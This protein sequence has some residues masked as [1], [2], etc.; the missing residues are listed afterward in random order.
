MLNPTLHTRNLSSSFSSLCLNSGQWQPLSAPKAKSLSLLS[1]A[2]S[3]GGKKAQRRSGGIRCSS[4]AAD[5]AQVSLLTKTKIP[6]KLKAVVTVNLT[7]GGIFSH[8]GIT[9]GLDDFADLMGRSIYLELLSK[10]LDPKTGS[11][12][13]PVGAYAHKIGH[14]PKEAK[15]E[16]EFSIPQEFGGVGAILVTNE[17]HKEIY[18]KDIVL[19]TDD[20]ESSSFTI[21]CQSWVHSKFDNHD[22]RIFFASKSYLPSD[23]PDG[24]KEYR[25][26]ELK[27]LRGNGTGERKVFERI[28]DYDV[29]NDLGDP[30]IHRDNA[31]PVLGGSKQFP[32]PRRC[33]T[34]RP[35][36]KSDPKMEKRAGNFYIPRDEAFSEIKQ[37]QFSA[38]TLRSVMHAVVPSINSALVD[39]NRSFPYFTA[40]DS[41]FDEGLNLGDQGDNAGN[42]FSTVI[43]RL[44]KVVS[45][46]DD[47][48]LRFEIPEMMERDKF[49]WFRD[50]EFSRQTL[51]G[52]NPF[53]IQLLT[54]FP[55]FSKL[56]PKIY[57]PA[58]SDI[59]K[60]II[61][62]EIRG[63]MTVE[64]ALKEKKLFILDFHDLYLPYVHKVR[65]LE[66]TT[67]Y[68]SRTIFFLNPDD[69]L[70]PIAIELTR[71]KSPTKP[72]WRQVFIN[73]WDATGTWLWRLAK[74]HVGAHDTGYHQLV[75]HWL[76]TH[77][78]AEP[79]I[80]ASNRQLS[81]MHPIYR[82]LFPH[83]R[84]TME[85]NALA[86][87]SLIN[88]GGIIEGGFSPGKFSVE[89]SSVAYDQ[90]WRFDMEALPAD[91]IRRGMAVEDPTAEHGLRLT[92]KDYPYAADGLLI[93]ST[94]KQW[95]TDYVN[96]YYQSSAQIMED[97][98]LQAWWAEIRNVGHGDKKDE[99]WWPVLDSTGSLI[100]ILTTIIWTVTGH[101]AAANFGQYHY[102]GYFPN[103][104]TTARVNLPVEEGEPADRMT[105][106]MIRPENELLKCFPSQMQA[107]VIMAV[108]DI[109][110][111]HSPD[112]EYLGVGP[113]AAYEAEPAVQAAF[114][115]FSGRLKEIEGI[116]DGRNLDVG[117]KNR[118]GAG[119]VPYELLKPFSDA[120]V[121]GK[122]IPTS[123]SI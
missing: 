15:Y 59:T 28:Y 13:K 27:A 105:E 81:A 35:K 115:R 73:S 44:I 63:Y 52:I 48:L 50:E 31:R 36:T 69:T 104:P 56:D 107:S 97:P 99:P 10:E 72:H 74:A 75:S 121:T 33:R 113:E 23:T 2:T 57:G 51:A 60:E 101:H 32:Y 4:E 1:P 39:R 108:L 119:I 20:D 42:V 6:T 61:E 76:R 88:A 109:L 14:D 116:I 87:E 92:I 38:K 7:I 71:P 111:S 49:S 12:K 30:D 106:F 26:K 86:R 70:R 55:I 94:L 45:E 66:N 58:K 18:L 79:Y 21:D 37:A 5:E 29:Y 19:T 95:V 93:W 24:L 98:E 118:C 91:L 82:L 3:A 68:G 117:L 64:Q 65:T 122:G 120:G 96:Q 89:L 112:E 16:G 54:E 62:R 67:L 41:L 47:F 90:L 103:R 80:I 123:I 40:I 114:E 46:A 11:E 34:G 77:C 8:V 22:K 25:D 84:Y 100:G 102:A 17:H 9:R 43:P 85:I 53:S 110:S 78:C 83:F